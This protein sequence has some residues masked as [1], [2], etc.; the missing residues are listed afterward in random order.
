MF[1]K[2]LDERNERLKEATNWKEFMQHLNAGCII[3]TPWCGDDAKEEEVKKR[4]AAESKEDSNSGSL[5]GAAKTLCIPKN[6]EPIKEGEKCFF[7]GKPA[8]HRV[9]WG[10]SY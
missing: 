6:Q 4:S 5:T 10:R 9:L 7:T 3:L 1:K 2:A 8:K